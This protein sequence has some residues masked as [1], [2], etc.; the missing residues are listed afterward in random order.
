MIRTVTLLGL[1]WVAM[2]CTWD[3]SPV[4]EAPIGSPDPLPGRYQGGAG[5]VVV[6]LRIES[7][8]RY[9]A[10]VFNGICPDGCGT[11]TGAGASHGTWD[12]EPTGLRLHTET[13]TE[14]LVLRMWN[15]HL[16]RIGR[17]LVLEA[18]GSDLRLVRQ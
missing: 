5:R 2:G 4:S 14:D 9:E 16:E 7:D 18:W 11:V 1:L 6:S 12:R 3:S 13:E 15:A 8:Y 10:W 17:D